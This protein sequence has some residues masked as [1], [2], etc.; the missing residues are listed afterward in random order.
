[1]EPKE[2]HK[3][4]VVSYVVRVVGRDPVGEE[5]V[6]EEVHRDRLQDTEVVI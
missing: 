5:E 1:V 4:V 6:E 3:Q 2:N